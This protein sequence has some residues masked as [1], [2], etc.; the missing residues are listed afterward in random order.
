MLGKVA[1]LIPGSPFI[2]RLRNDYKYIQSGI[3]FYFCT[4]VKFSEIG[5]YFLVVFPIQPAWVCR[6][7]GLKLDG[8]AEVV[9]RHQILRH[10]RDRDIVIFPVQLTTSRIGNHIQ[11]IHTLLK[12][13]AIAMPVG[14]ISRP[15][16]CLT[17]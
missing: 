17:V 14:Q 4:G 3:L 5:D 8:T 11:L 6:M 7:R 16:R 1:N 12:V 13:L 9:S 2:R 10:E 15:V